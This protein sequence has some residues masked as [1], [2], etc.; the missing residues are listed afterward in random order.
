MLQ[1]MPIMSTDK[2]L[3]EWIRAR[4]STNPTLKLYTLFD[5]SAHP[6]L[7]AKLWQLDG[8]INYEPLLLGVVED[9]TSLCAGPWLVETEPTSDWSKWF[10]QE[11]KRH[12]AGYLLCS[13]QSMQRVA[14]WMR[15]RS[16][17]ELADGRTGQFR[18]YDPRILVAYWNIATDAERAALLGPI[19][20]IWGWDQLESKAFE[21]QAPEG[22]RQLEEPGILC[23]EQDQLDAIN[24]RNEPYRMAQYLENH[25]FELVEG[26]SYEQLVILLHQ[27][28]LVVADR[29]GLEDARSR[30]MFVLLRLQPPDWLA[31]L[32]LEKRPWE[33]CNQ[34]FAQWVDNQSHN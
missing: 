18:C 4:L 31:G 19:Q 8:G 3:G 26:Y 28:M 17:V 30:F 7:P 13:D 34:S 6:D 25:C 2:S 1:V 15:N 33:A 14:D 27:D 29:L 11:L 9:T 10:V 20:C 23:L 12:A 24:R 32:H 22:A 5:P 21:L 16:A